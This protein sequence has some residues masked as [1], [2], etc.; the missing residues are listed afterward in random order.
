MRKIE[1]ILISSADSADCDGLARLVRDRNTAQKVVWRARIVLLAGEGK[2]AEG[3]CG[4][5]GREPADGLPL[6]PP[7]CSKRRRRAFEG[8]SPLVAGQ[9]V[10]AR[11]DQAGG[12]T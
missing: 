12:C 5:G 9:A 11:E 4:C 1:Q 2:T 8:R 3:I 10:D 7:L 6:V